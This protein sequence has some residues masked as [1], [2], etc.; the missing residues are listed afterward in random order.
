MPREL[1]GHY[2]WACQ[3][4]CLILTMPVV[5]Q[6][7]REPSWPLKGFLQQLHIHSLCF[8]PFPIMITPG[9]IL[10][11]IRACHFCL[12]FLSS[13]KHSQGLACSPFP[14]LLLAPSGAF[15]YL[16]ES[17][18]SVVESP[19]SKLLCHVC[20]ICFLNVFKSYFLLLLLKYISPSPTFPPLIIFSMP[21]I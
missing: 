6:R 19:S 3:W 12:A 1:A 7:S 10:T 20:S 16:Y 5:W 15:A 21:Y 17:P 13:A 4:R 2:F 9:T 11:I 18:D 8:L 14:M